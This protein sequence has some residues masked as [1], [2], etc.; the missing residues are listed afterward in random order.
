MLSFSQ[1]SSHGQSEG[2]LTGRKNPIVNRV[3]EASRQVERMC[4]N[5]IVPNRENFKKG[6]LRRG[7]G[8]DSKGSIEPCLWF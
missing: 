1:I 4:H 7:G 6:N 8:F 3:S 2:L 5:V